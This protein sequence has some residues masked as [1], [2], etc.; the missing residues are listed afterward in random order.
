M[1]TQTE[2]IARKRR[3]RKRGL[4][5]R[6]YFRLH[7]FE[8]VVFCYCF[9]LSNSK[10]VKSTENNNNNRHNSHWDFLERKNS[11]RFSFHARL[12]WHFETPRNFISFQPFL[13]HY[14]S[15]FISGKWK[16]TGKQMAKSKCEFCQL[17]WFWRMNDVRWRLQR[18]RKKR[19]KRDKRCQCIWRM[20]LFVRSFL[21]CLCLEIRCFCSSALFASI[22]LK[23]RE[24]S[25]QNSHT[26]CIFIS[27]SK[28]HRISSMINFKCVLIVA[29]KYALVRFRVQIISDHFFSRFIWFDVCSVVI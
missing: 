24:C 28:H 14:F 29:Y 9:L 18:V 5:F 27:P 3:R 12:I 1:H 21:L 26:N 23:A 13:C 7:A 4:W 17:S 22:K 16:R 25:K 15:L 2:I 10:T 19:A 20:I 8:S 11:R 6:K